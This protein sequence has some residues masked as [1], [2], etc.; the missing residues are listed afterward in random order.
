MMA[1]LLLKAWKGEGELQVHFQQLSNQ[2]IDINLVA[3]VGLNAAIEGGSIK[4]KILYAMI[5]DMPVVD[6]IKKIKTTIID[7][8]D[9]D[10]ADEEEEKEESKEKQEDSEI[11]KK[12]K[13]AFKKGNSKISQ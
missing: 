12:I 10:E 3:M 1:K 13:Q 4:K 6:D 8:G 9:E 11:V 5:N 7:I 2:F